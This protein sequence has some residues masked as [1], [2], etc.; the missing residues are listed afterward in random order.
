MYKPQK[1]IAILYGYIIGYND[2]SSLIHGISK[3]NV[4]W[5]IKKHFFIYIFIRGGPKR[6]W[7]TQVNEALQKRQWKIQCCVQISKCGD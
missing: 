2:I 5:I 4:S 6:D 7:N 3:K 1:I